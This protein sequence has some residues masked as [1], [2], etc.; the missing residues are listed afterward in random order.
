M[1]GQKQQLRFFLSRKI[2][3]ILAGGY[4][5]FYSSTSG[6]EFKEQR[7]FRISDSPKS[8][9]LTD[10]VVKENLQVRVKNPERGANIYI[11]CD[12][13]GS[14]LF[15]PRGGSKRQYMFELVS[16]LA[17]ACIGENNLVALLLHTDL[18]ERFDLLSANRANV[19]NV[20]GF[21]KDGK[22]KSRGTDLN[23][24][25]REFLEQSAGFEQKP[26]MVFLV[27]DFLT[28]G[29]EKRLKSLALEADCIALVLQ[30]P[31]EKEFPAM[32]GVVV[33]EDL[34]T[35]KTFYAS[36]TGDLYEELK[37]LFKKTQVEGVFLD[38]SRKAADGLSFLAQVLEENSGGE[39]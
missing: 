7:P 3:G 30:D 19:E 34:E 36:G 13:S 35:G 8:L 23:V 27:S 31:A 9:D 11:S 14:S 39:Q 25:L 37:T 1:N 22:T 18:V 26:D 21:I 20:C 6:F 4:A 32:P 38:V 24:P 5:S 33:C 15:G 2:H 17:E 12:I 10:W 16:L 28:R 29:F